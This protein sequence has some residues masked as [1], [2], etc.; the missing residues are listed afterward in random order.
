[1][2][3]QIEVGDGIF[4]RRLDSSDEAHIVAGLYLL[5]AQ[6]HAAFT[7]VRDAYE[8]IAPNL[9]PFTEHDFGIP[10]IDKLITDIEGE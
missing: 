3:L 10:Q 1:M 9:R 7:M 5:R 2:N 4:N 8:A 6:K